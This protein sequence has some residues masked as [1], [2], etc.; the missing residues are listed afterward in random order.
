MAGKHRKLAS[1]L[2]L[3]SAG[4]TGSPCATAAEAM[5]PAPLV[6]QEQGSFAVGGKIIST[7][8]TFNP[9]NHL[10]RLD[11]RC[12]AIMP[13]CLSEAGSGP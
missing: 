10:I 13:T 9:H 6:I 12:T 8:G 3:V 2:L 7:P 11:R 1:A 5:K 4:I